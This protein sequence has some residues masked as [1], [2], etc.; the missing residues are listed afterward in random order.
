[1]KKH[2]KHLQSHTLYMARIALGALTLVRNQ[3]R[4]C[5]SPEYHFNFPF[6]PLGFR[7]S[8][9]KPRGK[10]RSPPPVAFWKVL[11]GAVRKILSPKACTYT[12][13]SITPNTV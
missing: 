6:S 7:T 9:E 13:V 1:M 8:E 4:I 11:E 2:Y 12:L 3:T 10:G 5:Q